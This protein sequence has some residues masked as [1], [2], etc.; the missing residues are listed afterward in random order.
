MGAPAVGQT[1]GTLPHKESPS[2]LLTPSLSLPQGVLAGGASQVTLVHGAH[3]IF[4]ERWRLS[5]PCWDFHQWFQE[6]WVF[7]T[8]GRPLIIPLSKLPNI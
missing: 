3:F 4:I 1:Q 2:T 5:Q 8:L 7:Q 6:V